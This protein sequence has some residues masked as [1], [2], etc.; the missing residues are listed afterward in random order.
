LAFLEFPG[1][2]TPSPIYRLLAGRLINSAKASVSEVNPSSAGTTGI[3]GVFAFLETWMTTSDDFVRAQARALIRVLMHYGLDRESVGER[4]TIWRDVETF[5]HSVAAA[6]DLK[7]ISRKHA[8]MAAA[9]FCGGVKLR[10]PNSALYLALASFTRA[11]SPY[12]FLDSSRWIALSF[13]FR[14]KRA[15]AEAAIQSEVLERLEAA[16]AAEI[17]LGVRATP[18][19][20][21]VQAHPEKRASRDVSMSLDSVSG[22]CD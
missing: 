9:A 14:E 17:E 21:A 18:E 20:G 8:G 16:F 10:A 15:V 11:S 2:F 22:C 13:A 1:I 7:T 6:G 5:G 4:A 3:L 19:G 12:R